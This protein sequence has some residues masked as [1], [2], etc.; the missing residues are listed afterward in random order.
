MRKIFT[1]FLVLFFCAGF[2]VKAQMLA[3]FED[4]ADELVDWGKFPGWH[5]TRFVVGGDPQIAANPDK[6]GL[7]KS[8]KSLFAI[9]VA[10]AD[11]WGNFIEIHFIE[12]ITITESN[13]YLRYMAYRSIQPKNFRMAFNGHEDANQIFQ[14]KTP[15]EGEWVGM[16]ADVLGSPWAKALVAGDKDLELKYIKIILSNNWDNPRSGWGVATY[17]FDDFELSDNPMPPGVTLKDGNGLS[18]GF[19]DQAELNEWL[20][21]IDV[22]HQGNVCTIVDN[23]FTGSE[24]N[25]GGKVVQYDKSAGANWWQGPRID[26]NGVVSVGVDDDDPNP[27]FLHVMVFVPVDVFADGVI[28]KIKIQLCAKD[29]MGKENN[30]TFDIWD[31]QAG[32]WIDLVMEINKIAYLSEVTVRFDVRRNDDDTA[33]INAPANTFYFDA[34]AFDKDPDQRT[35]IIAGLPKITTGAFADIITLPG[36]IK[37]AVTQKANIQIYNMLG[38]TVKSAV[39]NGTITIPVANGIYIVKVTAGKNEKVTKVLVR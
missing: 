8:D 10:D 29:H 6:S 11:W 5:E 12:P 17:M 37:V 38:A 16:V 26:F 7:N 23:P 34:I 13:R 15:K 19:E 24:V 32:E 27:R 1:L 35:K 30:Q 28:E 2:S 9:N 18:I 22:Q 21:L 31:D 25:S 4:D 36:A 39:S 20:N 3:T 14:G 33:Y